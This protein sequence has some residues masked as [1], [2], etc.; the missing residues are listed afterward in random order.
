[1]MLYKFD[2]NLT[3]EDYYRFNVFMQTK[4]EN[5]KKNILFTR[6]LFTVLTLALSI[7]IYS[8]G[9]LNTMSIPFIITVLIVNLLFQIKYIT[10][11]KNSIR[12]T[13]EIFEK[14]GKFT[15]SP[16]STLEFDEE[17]IYE[18]TKDSKMEQILSE[19][20]GISIYNKYK[21]IYIHKNMAI[22]FILPYRIFENE[23]QKE[24]FIDFLKEKCVNKV[25]DV[26]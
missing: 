22:T 20:D 21:A 7:L 12:K 15:Y 3:D 11:V 23:K 16:T 26:N 17:R 13:I 25:V 4:T 24:E 18:T 9:T 2:V 14:Q 1:M 6:I 8:T 19:L 10:L 5:G